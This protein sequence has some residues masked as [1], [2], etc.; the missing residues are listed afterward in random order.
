MS[1]TNGL[2]T[3]TDFIN[4]SFQ[5]IN[6]SFQNINNEL[7]INSIHKALQFLSV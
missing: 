7:E 5:N 1:Q 3:K 4:N 6:N 2:L